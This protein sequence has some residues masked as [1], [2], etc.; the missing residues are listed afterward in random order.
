M[1]L[2]NFNPLFLLGVCGYYF[3]WTISHIA[4]HGDIPIICFWSWLILISNCW[5]NYQ[6]VHLRI[7]H[8]C[9]IDD[10]CT[11]MKSKKFENINIWK[12][13]QA[14]LYLSGRDTSTLFMLKWHQNLMIKNLEFL[15][16][17][18]LVG[19]GT[20]NTIA[21]QNHVLFSFL[22]PFLCNCLLG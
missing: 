17:N 6:F 13:C 5:L 9:F 18:I 16:S 22:L 15:V 7:W 20:M 4:S 8:F 3:W 11:G 14:T 10:V 21:A 19:F 12:L 1:V 2:N